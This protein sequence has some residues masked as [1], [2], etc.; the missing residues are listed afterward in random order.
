MGHRWSILNI[1][2]DQL[3]QHELGS[4]VVAQARADMGHGW[5]ILKIPL[6]QFGQQSD[7]KCY[8]SP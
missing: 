8:G 5:G 4:G 1:S 6:E 3:G 2:L 7:N